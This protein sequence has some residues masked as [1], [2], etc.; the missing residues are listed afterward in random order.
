[1][2]SKIIRFGIVGTNFITENFLSAGALEKNFSLNAIFSRSE[3]KAKEF[4]SKYGVE[5]T[6]TDL[7]KM[8]NSDLIDAV[9]IASPNALH[10]KYSKLFLEHKKHVFCEKPIASNEKE[11]KEMLEIAKK[12]NV[13]LMEGMKTT[14]L[15]NFKKIKDNLHKIGKVRRYFAS[16]CQYSSRYDK[17]KEGIVINAF[18][19]ELSN[20]AV[21]DIG[22]YTIYPMVCLFGIPNK[23]KANAIMLESGVDAQ[24][25]AIFDYDD[26]DGMVIYS[27]ISNSYLPSEIQGE[28]GSII[29]DH[30]NTMENISIMYKDG[31]T[32]VISESQEKYDMI[33]EIQ[34]FIQ[35]INDNLLESNVNSN[36]NSLETIKILQEIRHQVGVVFPAD[37]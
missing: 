4:A 13:V 12:N 15:P 21:M 2:T 11:V 37:I 1:M 6:F 3:E 22:I 16:Y 7:E 27:K 32:E 28:E 8:A 31:T 20:G 23:I 14:L 34:E 18:K 29:I 5:N 35:I 10:C 24:G 9:Y 36:S 25:S 19:P 33:Y 26:M 30:I 17:Y